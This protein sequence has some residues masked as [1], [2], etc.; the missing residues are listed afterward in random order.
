MSKHVPYLSRISLIAAHN[1]VDLRDR[2]H[3]LLRFFPRRQHAGKLLDAR[4]R[5]RQPGDNRFTDLGG[6]SVPV[7]RGTLSGN[8]HTPLGVRLSDMLS[9]DEV[10]FFANV[11]ELVKTN[12]ASPDLIA[13]AD[14]RLLEFVGELTADGTEMRHVIM[15]G[16]LQGGYTFSQDGVDVTVDFG[17]NELTAP[18]TSWANAASTPV[19]DIAAWIQE[20]QENSD[21]HPPT[22]VFYNPKVYSEFLLGNTEWQTYVKAVPSLA[23]GFLGSVGGRGSDPG[24]S[25]TDPITGAFVDEMWGL[26]WVPVRGKYRAHSTGALTDRWDVNKL[27]LAAIDTDALRVLEWGMVNDPGYN[28]EAKSNYEFEEM[29]DPKGTKVLYYD[30]GGAVVLRPERVQV[31]ADLTP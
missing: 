16:A 27:T 3:P 26:M 22:H 24:D 20:F 18:A 21:G 7:R 12:M 4:T 15:A 1:V 23:R 9:P 6:K 19:Q 10:A 17:L 25:L 29:T 28:P 30:N 5:R 31:V 13:E 14:R 8:L 11:D 2:L